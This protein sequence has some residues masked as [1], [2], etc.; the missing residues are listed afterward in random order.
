MT[1]A[2]I[3]LLI[4]LLVPWWVGAVTIVSWLVDAMVR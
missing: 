2:P 1:R 4:A 3:A